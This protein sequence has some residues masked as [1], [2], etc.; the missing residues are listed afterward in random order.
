M[1]SPEPDALKAEFERFDSDRNGTIDEDEFERLV[2]A[3]GITLSPEHTHTAFLA[4]DVNGN[5]VIEFGEFA[6][7]WKR[8]VQ[9]PG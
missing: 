2:R 5:G 9:P 1:A 4:I 3:L 7:W 6:G 8:H